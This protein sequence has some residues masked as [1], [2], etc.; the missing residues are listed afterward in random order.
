MRI[1]PV[2]EE[3]PTYHNW[4]NA[5]KAKRIDYIMISKGDAIVNEYRTVN[6][7]HGDAYSSDHYSVY[8]KVILK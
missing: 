6:N 5:E 2:T 7:L 4:G 3:T 1:S 8:I